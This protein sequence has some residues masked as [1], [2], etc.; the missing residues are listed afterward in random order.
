M[1]LKLK[2]LRSDGGGEFTSKKIKEFLESEDIFHEMT[3]PYSPEQNGLAEAKFRVLFK[4]ARAM[5]HQAK[6][7]GVFFGYAVKYACYIYNRTL[8]ERKDKSTQVPYISLFGHKPDLSRIRVFGCLAYYKIEGYVDKTA[9]K[10]IP[11]IFVGIP[12]HIKGWTLWIPGKGERVSRNVAFNEN[13]PGGELLTTNAHELR[14]T[15]E[16][17]VISPADTIS[18]PAPTSPGTITANPTVENCLETPSTPVLEERTQQ[19][20]LHSLLR[21]VGVPEILRAALDNYFQVDTVNTVIEMPNRKAADIPVPLSL[22]DVIGNKYEVQWVD[23][24]TK[25]LQALFEMKTFKRIA[26]TKGMRVITTRFVFKV[27]SK[28]DGSIEKFKARLVVQGCK[29]KKG[30]DYHETYSPV[31]RAS[32]LRIIIHM[33]Q[34]YGRSFHNYDVQNAYVNAD[35]QDNVIVAIPGLE[36]VYL[37]QGSLYGA[38]QACLNWHIKLRDTFLGVGFTQSKFDSGLF[39]KRKEGNTDV[40]GEY[41]DDL[42][43]CLNEP[44]KLIE[45]LAPMLKITGGPTEQIL[46]I[47]VTQQDNEIRVF[48]AKNIMESVKKQGLEEA[49]KKFVPGTQVIDESTENV[50]QKI[51]RSLVGSCM[52]PALYCRPDVSHAVRYCSQFSHCANKSALKAAK[53]ILKYLLHT[54][55]DYLVFRGNMELMGYVDA[56]YANDKTDRRSV[57]GYI[58]FLGESPI[59]WK[60]KKQTLVTLSTTEAEYIAIS[61]AVQ[62]GK[63]LRGLLNEL[64]FPQKTTKLYNDNLS[65]VRICNN[66]DATFDRTK[67]IDVKFRFVKEALIELEFELLHCGTEENRADGFTKNLGKTLF[68]RWK[69]SIGLR[70]SVAN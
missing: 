25:E 22:Q 10:S 49:K 27:K 55:D 46:G 34:Y 17:S 69:E 1:R 28:P 63:Y 43:M 9:A 52:H 65:A 16:A 59:S 45:S 62:E 48:A 42:P 20:E 51:Y 38:P 40:V 3:S 15:Q 6:L 30:V 37:L 39:F 18:Q 66:Q 44:E 26:R 64:G 56:D 21:E 8:R 53:K 12:E 54:K 7:P 29:M 68:K 4:M 47:N 57:T 13:K 5:L 67:H 70:E 58:F 41:I 19:Q 35:M 31:M 23:A 33:C 36:D 14:D 60:S 32:S 11:G 24:I 2:V 61:E 50:D